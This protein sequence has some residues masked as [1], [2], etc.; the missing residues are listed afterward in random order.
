[1][2]IRSGQSDRI[3]PNTSFETHPDIWLSMLAYF[4]SGVMGSPEQANGRLSAK[5]T[6]SRGPL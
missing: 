1:L 2:A 4:I 5:K 6:R 3:K